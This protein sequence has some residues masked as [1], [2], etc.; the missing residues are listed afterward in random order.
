MC[1][2]TKVAG[3]GTVALQNRPADSE[4][5]GFGA[6]AAGWAGPSQLE[7]EVVLTCYITYVKTQKKI[8]LLHGWAGPSQLEFEVVLTCYIT[9]VKTQKKIFLLHAL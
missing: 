6:A 5:G 8:F 7:F 3:I 2:K 1:D 4:A 9:Y